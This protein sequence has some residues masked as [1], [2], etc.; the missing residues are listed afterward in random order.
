MVWFDVSCL[1]RN[2]SYSLLYLSL[3]RGVSLFIFEDKTRWETSEFCFF[4]R[5]IIHHL[6]RS[7]ESIDLLVT[8]LHRVTRDVILTPIDSFIHVSI[9]HTN[10]VL[11]YLRVEGSAG[12]YYRILVNFRLWNIVLHS[13]THLVLDLRLAHLF[14]HLG[15]FLLLSFYIFEDFVPDHF[16]HTLFGGVWI[17]RRSRVKVTIWSATITFLLY[18]HLVLCFFIA[19]LGARCHFVSLWDIL[20]SGIIS[21]SNRGID[22]LWPITHVMSL[23][24]LTRL[25]RCWD[26]HD[27]LGPSW[28][29]IPVII[30]INIVHINLRIVKAY[31]FTLLLL[32]LQ[33]GRQSC[34]VAFL[35]LLFL[36]IT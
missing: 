22:F 36:V 21:Q 14:R 18:S 4:K 7:R 5:A 28:H 34:I 33:N 16:R 9:R 26:I 17:S 6:R 1:E 13:P 20:F 32:M 19:K 8:I 31:T 12:I 15:K 3:C 10:L 2:S 30:N 23:T 27:V 11:A 29:I 24:S 25:V 35:F